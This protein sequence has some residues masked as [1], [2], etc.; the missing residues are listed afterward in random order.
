M[1]NLMM[2]L[3]DVMNMVSHFKYAVNHN[4]VMSFSEYK[5]RFSYAEDLDVCDCEPFVYVDA[6]NAGEDFSVGTIV[7]AMV[8][9]GERTHIVSVYGQD[10]YFGYP[11]LCVEKDE[12][13]PGFVYMNIEYVGIS[14]VYD[15][16]ERMDISPVACIN[17][18]TGRV[19][20][21]ELFERQR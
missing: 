17:L 10:S 11:R 6:D 20:W 14:D 2:E 16:T 7:S 12:E 13:N 19:F 3:F 1:Y 15:V 9:D 21:H 18:V 8:L 4:M 5:E